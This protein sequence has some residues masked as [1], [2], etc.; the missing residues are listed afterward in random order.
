M[1]FLILGM[2]LMNKA[3]SVTL[4]HMISSSCPVIMILCGIGVVGH[5]VFNEERT[6]VICALEPCYSSAV[7]YTFSFWFLWVVFYTC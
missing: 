7:L 1:D 2:W 3:P 4:D 6:I 5:Y